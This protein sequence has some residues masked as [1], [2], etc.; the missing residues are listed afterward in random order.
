MKHQTA[1]AV[2]TPLTTALAAPADNKARQFGGF[3]GFSLPAG[4]GFSVP[5]GTGITIPTGSFPGF[6]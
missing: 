1:I 2:L 5:T 3:G 4:S 6:P